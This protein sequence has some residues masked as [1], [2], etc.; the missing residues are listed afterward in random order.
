MND[1]RM[2][3]FARRSKVEDAI[4]WVDSVV[5]CLPKED[6]PLAEAAG[7][8][9]AEEVV[10][11]VDVPGYDRAMMDG[12]ALL[13]ADTAGATN[14]QRLAI[15]IIGDSFPARPFDGK[16][17]PG[18]A[19]RIMTGSPFP[20]GADAVLPVE[21]VQFEEKTVYVCGE[22][23]PGKHIGRRGED[24]AVG[25]IALSAGRRLRPQ[26]VGLLSSIGVPKPPVVRRP[27][28]RIVP[29]GNELLPPGSIPSEYRIVDSN[30][31]MLRALVERDGGRVICSDIVP[32]DPD[33]ILAAMREDVDV[34]LVS[35]GSSVG[36]E[37]HA[38]QLIAEHG[39]LAIHG[40]AMRPSSPAGMGTLD[41][42]L[43]FLLPGNPASCLCAYDFFAGRAIRQLAGL[44]SRWPYRKIDAP[45]RRKLVSVVGRLDYARVAIVE[46]HVEPIAISGASILSST[47]RA[48][49]FVVLPADC[50]GYGEGTMVEVFLYDTIA[51]S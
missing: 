42:K 34:V 13:A 15:N 38:P 27:R 20:A 35:G 9:L 1:I 7:R 3:G 44:P 16:V 50:E 11:R 47:V 28:V 17:T 21:Q 39:L 40:I 4:A 26:D 36:E 12:L 48:D 24:L 49:G 46:G 43:V 41:K 14:Y 8:V 23:P 30:S 25:A 37:D 10:S 2:K 22:V 5:R 18:T 29:T 33:Q 6:V 32:D 19:V 31:P 45:L 51:S